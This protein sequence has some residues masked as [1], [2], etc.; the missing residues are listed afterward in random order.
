MKPFEVYCVV[1]VVNA[2]SL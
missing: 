1:T 2:V